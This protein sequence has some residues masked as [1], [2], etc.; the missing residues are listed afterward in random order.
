MEHPLENIQICVTCLRHILIYT[1]ENH[2]ARVHQGYQ[3]THSLVF[4]SRMIIALIVLAMSL[5]SSCQMFGNKPLPT[6]TPVPVKPESVI[7][8][9][10][11][12]SIKPGHSNEIELKTTLRNCSIVDTQSIT[13]TI[14][15]PTRLTTSTLLAQSKN[16][17]FS[18]KLECPLPQ[19][20]QD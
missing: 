15:G 12:E 18:P 10:C 11:L 13:S 14:T 1:Y 3:G 7:P 17:T 20:Y 2:D 4:S 19:T 9:P 16:V 8:P 6:P 5:T